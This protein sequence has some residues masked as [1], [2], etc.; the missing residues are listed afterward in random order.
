MDDS[1]N[2]IAIGGAAGLFLLAIVIVAVTLIDTKDSGDSWKGW[3]VSLKPK[4]WG[5]LA[6]AVI[7]V[8]A[9]CFLL[10]SY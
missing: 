7:C 3:A 9:A 8:V 4:D 10:A 2:W 5:C 1:P 6:V